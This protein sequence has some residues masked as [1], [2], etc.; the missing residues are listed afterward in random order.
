MLCS[1]IL[2]GPMARA[3]DSAATVTAPPATPASATR[4]AAAR[5]AADAPAT[6]V[7]EPP[8]PTLVALAVYI[9]GA[10]L[11]GYRALGGLF[12]VNPTSDQY[13]AGYAF[14]EFGASTL[15]HTGGFPLW[16]PYLF[17]GMPYV[18]AMHGDIFYPTFLLRMLMPTD[19]AM[20]WGFILH[21]V[22]AGFFTYMF[23]R[24]VGL[25]FFAALVGGLAYSM[26]GNV[27]GL[28]SPGHDGKLYISALL[29]LTLVVAHHAI[30]RGRVWAYGA[31]ALVITL[32]VLTPHPQL[33]QY[34][35]LLTGAWALYLAF[36]A[37][38][39]GR[40]LDRRQR[41]VR[42]GGALVAVGV[43]LLGGAI[44]FAP[45]VEY[46]PWS[47]RAGGKGWD[48]AISYSMPPEELINTY[49]PQFSGI[50]DS[51]AGRNGIHFHSEYVGAAVLVLAVLGT[52]FG[53]TAAARK[54]RW[55]WIGTL[56]V[57]VLWALGGFTPFYHL[58]YALVPG[59]KYFRA[60]STMLYLVSFAI[61]ILAGFG[62]QRAL[63][64]RTSLRYAIGWAIAAGLVALLAT[65]GMLTNLAAGF[66]IPGREM[67]VDANKGAL[68]VGAWRS[69]AFVAV[70]LAL[71]LAV[72]RRR[73]SSRAAGWALAAVVAVDLWSI[74]R[75]Y[76]RFSAPA[77]ELYASDP[78]IDYLRKLPQPG[79]VVPLAT[80]ELNRAA[81][82]PYFGGGGDGRADGLMVHGIRSVA[83]YHGNELDR[84]LVLSGWGEGAS[85]PSQW[86]WPRQLGNPNFWRLA[87]IQYLYS[88]DAKPPLDGMR[89]VAGPARNAAGNMSYLYAFP[90]ENP[91]AWVTSIAVKAPDDNVLA[92]V[93]D[94][95]FDVSRVAL[96][97]T[98][99]GV[100]TQAVP[101]QLPA[102]PG[103]RVHF[104]RYDAGHI[105][106]DLDKPAPRGA[107]L[108]VSENFYPGWSATV[109]GRAVPVGRTDFVLTGLTL[110][111][112]G[113]HVEL[114]F[115][116]APYHTGKLLTLA[117]LGAGA[118][119]LLAGLVVDRRRT[120]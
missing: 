111:E 63:E 97:D 66:V 50:L 86:P 68:T 15:R 1:E 13:I 24:A 82:D 57:A 78:V 107:A 19:A 3:D 84:Y 98:A 100:A 56:I 44:Q 94:P 77:K 70:A 51:Y 62:T 17:D 40:A 12:L 48:H 71:L 31:L 74:E 58:V 4:R 112:G 45:V 14:R 60:P 2:P 8:R 69:F 30:R 110:P 54:L 103:V 52:G 41:V 92:T 75:L 117:A 79:R 42:L 25:G 43:G 88:N 26:G 116:S 9:V 93:L 96:F 46:T 49:L 18:A 72:A 80:Q 39:A 102:A 36:G 91:A 20:T 11:L 95:R 59:T 81:L 73:I 90:G 7:A 35:L 29:P 101:Q 76:W 47:P 106:L 32:G 120:A 64:G 55:F 37:D 113:R 21:V 53:T 67:L 109:D 118:L 28:V 22:L 83:G 108:V 23:L 119:V 5:S 87:N 34:L 33:L 114:T 61:A 105:V 16:N 38:D 27:A 85:A 99:A 65:G 115:D 89:L 104:T 6:I 10:L